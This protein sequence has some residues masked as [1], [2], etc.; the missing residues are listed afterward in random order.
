[1]ENELKYYHA[2]KKSLPI[3]QSLNT[4]TGRADGNILKGGAVYLTSDIKSCKRYGT[5]YEIA[6]KNVISYKAALKAVGRSKKARYT[7]NVF[8]AK[9]ADTIIKKQI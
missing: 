9:P 7:R 1:M 6:A 2:S 3:G 8:I 5:V 4:K